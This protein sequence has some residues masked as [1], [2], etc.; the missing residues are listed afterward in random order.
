MNKIPRFAREYA[1]YI[2]HRYFSGYSADIENLL[3]HLALGRI[4]IREVMSK[5]AEI[6]NDYEQKGAER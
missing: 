4:T 1:N 6:N 5:L 2:E 3:A